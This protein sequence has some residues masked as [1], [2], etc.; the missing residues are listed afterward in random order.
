LLLFWRQNHLRVDGSRHGQGRAY[1]LHEFQKPRPTTVRLRAKREILFHDGPVLNG[2]AR[3]VR[4]SD[5]GDEQQR[6]QLAAHHQDADEHVKKI[7]RLRTSTYKTR[8]PEYE[9]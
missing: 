1:S 8:F 6:L 2:H 4:R 7:A 9:T 3:Y 5:I